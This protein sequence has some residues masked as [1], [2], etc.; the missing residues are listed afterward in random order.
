MVLKPGKSWDILFYIFYIS[1][2]DRRISEPPTVGDKLINPIA[3]VYLPITRIP[4]SRWDEF[5]PNVK[6][7]M[8]RPRL[9]AK[10]RGDEILHNYIGIDGID[11]KNKQ[12]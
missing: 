3:G 2:G 4:F 8:T 12:L 1:T 10:N 9:F 7:G 5:I 11:L 6:G